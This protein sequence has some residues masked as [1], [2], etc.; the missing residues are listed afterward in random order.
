MTHDLVLPLTLL[1]V[2]GWL[3]LLVGRDAF[4]RAGPRIDQGRPRRMRRWPH[5]VAVVPA[6]NE[7]ACVGRALQSLMNQDYPGRLNIILVDDHSTDATS[8]IAR[9]LPT[10][11]GRT[12]E[13]IDARPLPPGWSGKLWAVSEGL[14]H[15]GRG[16]PEAPYVLLTDADIA[17]DS[18]NLRRLVAKA[19]ANRLDLVSVMVKLNCSSLWE[20]LLIP[21]F[22]FFF[23]KLYPFAAVNRPERPEAAAAGGCALVRRVALARAGGIAAIRGCLIDDVALGQL[24]KHRPQPNVGRIWL[25]LTGGTDSLR[26]QA[27]LGEIWA[28]VARTADTQLGHSAGLLALTVPAM[29]ALYLV[30]PLALVSWP[31]HGSLYVAALASVAWLCMASAYWPTLRLYGLGA[32]WSLTL[33]LAG[34]L[35]TAMT[36]D[37]ALQYRRGMGGRW[38]GRVAAPVALPREAQDRLVLD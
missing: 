20:R 7:A 30:P 24:I 1:S 3:Y 6:R 27:T 37:S 11:P 29:I 5:V 35:Y 13:V 2:L 25:G 4:W 14:A 8:A 23:R 36:I 10:K 38:K 31:M 9:A 32:L 33:P 21:P 34:A 19:E 15:A 16:A 18:G 12:L 17:H 28:M 22:V 26:R